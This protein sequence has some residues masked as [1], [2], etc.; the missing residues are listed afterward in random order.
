MNTT[1]TV[2]IALTIVIAAVLSGCIT[3]T[4]ANKDDETLERMARIEAIVNDP[5]YVDNEE[6]RIAIASEIE[7]ITGEKYDLK[8]QL[9]E[10]STNHRQVSLTVMPDVVDPV[11]GKGS[12]IV[13]LTGGKDYHLLK[14]VRVLVNN[15]TIDVYPADQYPREIGCTIIGDW[16]IRVEGT[17]TD[18]EVQTLISTRLNGMPNPK[19]NT[20]SGPFSERYVEPSD[21]MTYDEAKKLAEEHGV[22]WDCEDPTPTPTMPKVTPTPV[23]T[24]EFLSYIEATIDRTQWNDN[25]IAFL[26]I[27]D[28]RTNHDTLNYLD[29]I[30]IYLDDQCVIEFEPTMVKGNT[31]ME[32]EECPMIIKLPNGMSNTGEIT[33]ICSFSEPGITTPNGDYPVRVNARTPPMDYEE[34]YSQFPV[35]NP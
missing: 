21:G 32:I 26:C 13:Q 12:F 28:Y 30:K 25:T 2:I 27:N 8:S 35:W 9:N 15:E 4:N 20:G 23:P 14:E 33:A 11:A 16:N 24:P 22:V 3:D 29:Y 19:T 17:Y 7:K 10:T 34:E 1:K 18:G 6:T 31:R 5:N